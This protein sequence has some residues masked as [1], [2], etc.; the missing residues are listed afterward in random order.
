[1]VDIIDAAPTGRA[2]CRGCGRPIAKGEMRFGERLPN[3]YGEGEASFWFH[4]ACGACMRAEKFATAW[5]QTDL[6]PIDRELIEG[7]NALARQF[8]R[9]E[10]FAGV[11]R[12]SSG[13]AQC[14]ACR[15]LIEKGSWRV[16]LQIY[17]DG[18][19]N[20]IGY[21]HVACASEYFGTAEFLRVMAS[22]ESG[23]SPAD[24]AEI[25]RLGSVPRLAKARPEH[26][27]SSNEGQ[28]P[29]SSEDSSES[30]ARRS[31]P[32]TG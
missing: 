32:K 21:V 26:M 20:P 19:M 6:T 18:R 16:S 9:L 31:E 3:A 22:L 30:D 1:M 27:E 8:P 4:L 17:E 7:L 15:E 28:S 25:T 14:R 2:K 13:R 12:A 11:E 23:L 29:S 5:A 10:R 24:L